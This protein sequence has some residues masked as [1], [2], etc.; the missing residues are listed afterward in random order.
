MPVDQ[1]GSNG[2]ERINSHY[3]MYK[4]G[5]ELYAKQIW[6][7]SAIQK[8]LPD[9]TAWQPNPQSLSRA[10]ES[11]L[12]WMIQNEMD[13]AEETFARLFPDIKHNFEN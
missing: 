4:I 7:S 11:N 3:S 9:Y 8:E 1:I 13:D 10:D 5:Q 6:D 12:Q 2:Y